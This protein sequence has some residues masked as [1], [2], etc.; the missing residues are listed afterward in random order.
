MVRHIDTV[1]IQNS[2]QLKGVPGGLIAPRD[3]LN[4]LNTSALPTPSFP[5][6]GLPSTGFSKFKRTT[7]SG[8]SSG[9]G[10]ALARRGND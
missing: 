2:D 7:S 4:S 6:P 8:L 1:Y 10:V 5:S 9:A 3:A